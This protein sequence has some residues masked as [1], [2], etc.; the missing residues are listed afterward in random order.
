MVYRKQR[1]FANPNPNRRG[2]FLNP[3]RRDR[4]PNSTRD[5]G[6]EYPKPD[7]FVIPSF[8]GNLDIKSPLIWIDEVDKLFDMSYI[9]IENHIKFVAYKL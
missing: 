3:N 1:R 7:E 9:P 2:K 4:F 8:D 6:R 5:K